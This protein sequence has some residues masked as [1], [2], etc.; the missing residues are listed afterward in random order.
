MIRYPAKSAVLLSAAL[1]SACSFMS[2]QPENGQPAVSAPEAQT[3][4]QQGLT[5]YRGNQFEAAL[6][7]LD[8]AATSGR[9]KSSDEVNARKHIAF[10]HCAGAREAACRE[11]FQA[12]MRI[13]PKFDLAQN[14]A[15]HPAWGPVWRSLKGA[16]AEKQAI[17]QASRLMASSGQTRLVEGIKQYEDGFYNEALASFQTALANGLPAL[18]DEIRAHKYSAYVYCLTERAAM[19]RAT[20]RKIFTLDPDFEML[21]SENGHPAWASIYRQEKAAA[22]RGRK[23]G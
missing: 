12:I 18:A 17:K 8:A 9:L 20:F 19:C 5:S 6:K 15:G 7:Q 1:L 22:R 11:Q 21:P 4:Y 3:L 14:E 13:E 23:I 10:I 16:L 2:K